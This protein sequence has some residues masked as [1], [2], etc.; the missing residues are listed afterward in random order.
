MSLNITSA[1]EGIVSTVSIVENLPSPPST[2]CSVGL[3]VMCAAHAP[4][5]RMHLAGSLS[6]FA[7]T[8]AL[9]FFSFCTALLRQCGDD[10]RER[11]E[12]CALEGVEVKAFNDGFP[13]FTTFPQHAWFPVA[14]RTQNGGGNQKLRA[15]RSR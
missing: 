4:R 8:V 7:T 13:S 15:V 12:V 11:E 10:L 2:A 5:L 9:Y 3:G 6:H 14:E 1:L